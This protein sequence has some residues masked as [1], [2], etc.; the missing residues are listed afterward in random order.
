VGRS[1]LVSLVD[2]GYTP[3]AIISGSEESAKSL[4]DN[5]G[6]EN[7][8]TSYEILSEDSELIVIAVQDDRLE[9][10]VAKLASTI[11][12]NSVPLIVHTSGIQE[13]TIM[14][15]LLQK[16]AKIAS[17]HPVASFPK[18]KI[19]SLKDVHFGVEGTNADEAV[20]LVESMGGIPFLI[21]TGKK[22]LYHAACT[23][24]SGYLNTLLTVSEELM[25]QAGIKSPKSMI[26]D[27]ANTAIENWDEA[28]VLAITGS[29][30]RGDVDSVRKHMDSMD[31][32]D[33][34]WAVYLELALKTIELCRDAGL[35]N[36]EISLEIKNIL[37]RDKP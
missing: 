17:I 27:L 8:G 19:L 9:N 31:K 24:A 6:A 30:A 25:V 35:I 21:E 36:E 13:S 28:G 34:N 16:G 23:V 20:E 4:A 32:H 14:D 22:A 37:T 1:I 10:V 18:N 2:A 3:S 11:Q 7:F 5:V 12:F 15:S 29:I 33:K 26:S